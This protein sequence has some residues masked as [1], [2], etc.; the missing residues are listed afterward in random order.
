MAALGFAYYLRARRRVAAIRQEIAAG[1]MAH[2]M[3]NEAADHA[4]RRRE[5][6]VA[7]VTGLPL[8][9]PLAPDRRRG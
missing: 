2:H 1:R 7:S 4:F 3:V 5:V 6:K 8:K 9:K